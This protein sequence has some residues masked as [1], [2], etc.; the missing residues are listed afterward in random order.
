MAKSWT[1]FGSSLVFHSLTH[2]EVGLQG[3]PVVPVGL[4]EEGRKE[5]GRSEWTFGVFLVFVTIDNAGVDT[6]VCKC[7]PEILVISLE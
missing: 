1:L 4:P 7:L 2:T 6:L 3:L 5:I